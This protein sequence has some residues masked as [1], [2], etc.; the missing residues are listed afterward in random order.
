MSHIDAVV[1]AD[2][3]ES[4]RFLAFD[5]L[6]VLEALGPAAAEDDWIVLDFDPIGSE[7]AHQIADDVEHKALEREQVGV[8][9]SGDAFSRLARSVNQTIDGTFVGVPP[10][11]RDGAQLARL[12]DLSQFD[13]NGA[14]RVIKA[15]DSSYWVVV[16]KTAAELEAVRRAFRDVREGDA[17]AELGLGS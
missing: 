4:G 1:I 2:R 6:D 12:A 15:I 14:R 8:V 3:D 5:L 10:G 11:K 13:R 17:A 16:T 7:Q 9:L